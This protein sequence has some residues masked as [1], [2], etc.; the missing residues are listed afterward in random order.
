MRKEGIPAYFYHGDT[1]SSV[2]IGAWPRSAVQE[3]QESSASTSDPN[4]PL[5]VLSQPLPAGSPTKF[6]DRQTGQPLQAVAPRL[7]P[8]DPSM[9]EAMKKYPNEVVNGVIDITKVKDPATGQEKEI[10]DPSFL[11]V[12]PHKQQSILDNP[13]SSDEGEMTVSAPPGVLAPSAEPQ[14]IGG[15]LRSLGD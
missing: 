14:P 12:I 7:V 11:V 6:V 1:I 3:Q 9:I 10:P 4:Q 5:L 8:L 2:C 15:K 13:P